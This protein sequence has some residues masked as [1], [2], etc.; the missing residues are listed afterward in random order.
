MH[1]PQ[2]V[3]RLACLG[4]VLV[5]AGSRPVHA[6]IQLPP[7]QGQTVHDFA[8]VLAAEH[9]AEMERR[10]RELFGKT[11]VAIVVIT[12][13]ALDGEPIEEFAVRVGTEWGVGKS[14]EDRGIVAA[15]AIE[16]RGIYIATGYGVEGFLPDGR[17]GGILDGAAPLLVRN[18]FS[19]GLLHISAALVAAAADE[20]GVTIEG[21]AAV[22]TQPRRPGRGLERAPAN[23]LV[24]LFMLAVLG[25]LVVRHPRLLLLMLLFSGVGRGFGGYGMRRGGFGGGGFGGGSGF[26]GFGGGGFGGGGAGR[27]F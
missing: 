10:H 5:A 1:L 22:S 13:P 14:D 26:G 15:L 9:A 2:R 16:E 6:Q 23:P 27:V 3:V 4:A 25:Y 11:E 7:P 8:G 20:Y 18:D 21:S 12:V 19:A 24:V 17:V